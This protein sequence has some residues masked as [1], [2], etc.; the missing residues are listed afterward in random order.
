MA[1]GTTQ[2]DKRSLSQLWQENHGNFLLGVLAIIVLIGCT[3]LLWP[4]S[5]NPSR[6][7]LVPGAT[8]QSGDD[9]DPSTMDESTNQLDTTD[10]GMGDGNELVDETDTALLRVKIIGLKSDRGIVRV[11]I[12]SSEESFNSPEQAL[13]KTELGIDGT[14]AT[15]EVRVPAGTPIAIA[16]YHDQNENGNLDKNIL[17]L[18]TEKYGFSL[19]KRSP[20]GP[21]RF[22]DASFT[23]QP[24]VVEVPLQV[25]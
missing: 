12:Y 16:A 25:W 10:R 18:P 19:G 22:E 11:A 23:P 21:P 7:F 20:L 2:D 17:G 9:E 13:L 4:G 1:K 15:W 14:E 8:L 6:P 3:L 24:G 5:D